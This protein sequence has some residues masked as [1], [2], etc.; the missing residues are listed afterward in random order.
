[1]KTAIVIGGTGL[2][3]TQLINLLLN[4]QDFEK[5]AVF[6]RQSLN[7][8]NQ[9]LEEHIINFTTPENWRNL[10]KGDVL[11]SCMGTTLA[12]SGSKEE[13]YKIDFTYQY[14]F[15][16]IASRNKVSD[17]VLISSA[18][19]NIKSPFFYL[20]MKG[21][22]E[23]E[24]K[25]LPFKKIVIVQP[26]Q[27]YGNRHERRVGESITVALSKA[28]NKIGLFRKRRPIHARRVAEAMIE[29][30]EYYDSSAVV[31]SYELFGLAKFYDRNKNVYYKKSYFR[32][33]CS[34]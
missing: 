3:G 7:I 30:L 19:A 27:L 22:L 26:A 14:T 15:A 23:T 1:M 8:K 18:G 33:L 13:Q 25:K 9:K 16:D 31:S 4:D 28:L 20:R 11:F 24:V 5:I 10:V 12:K 21:E 17:Y 2:V 34:D 6:G 29:S 32:G